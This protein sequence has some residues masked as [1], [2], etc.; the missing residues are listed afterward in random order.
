MTLGIITPLHATATCQNTP[1][2]AARHI[3]QN[4]D[5]IQI[6]NTS[7]IIDGHCYHSDH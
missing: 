1:Q 6:T 5:V 7:Q 4:I 3:T 2:E